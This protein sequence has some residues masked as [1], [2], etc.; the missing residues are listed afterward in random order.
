MQRRR[1]A[2]SFSN[3]FPIR[4]N[5]P[6]GQGPPWGAKNRLA[7]VRGLDIWEGER[8]QYAFQNSSNRRET[9]MQEFQWLKLNTFSFHKDL[10]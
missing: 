2:E 3:L 1:T 5:K 9:T 10:R 6:A 4:T 7:K 8:G